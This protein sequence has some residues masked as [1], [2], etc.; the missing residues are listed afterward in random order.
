MQTVRLGTR[1]IIDCREATAAFMKEGCVVEELL[2]EHN[3]AC[4]NLGSTLNLDNI[5]NILAT[6]HASNKIHC[7]ISLAKGVML[8]D[9]KRCAKCVLEIASATGADMPHF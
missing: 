5:E 8:G 1:N 7:T 9:A 3:V 4:I 6:I 2:N